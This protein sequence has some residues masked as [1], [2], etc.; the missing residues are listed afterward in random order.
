MRRWHEPFISA[1]DGGSGVAFLME[2][3]RHVKKLDTRFGP[4]TA[5]DPRAG[6]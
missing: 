2:L 4:L 1:N 5:G 3:A 6:S